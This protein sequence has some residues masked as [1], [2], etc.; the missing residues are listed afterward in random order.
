MCK[1]KLGLSDLIRV[2]EM[3]YGQKLHKL[4]TPGSWGRARL[5]VCGTAPCTTIPETGDHTKGF[6]LLVV[7]KMCAFI[8][9]LSHAGDRRREAPPESLKAHSK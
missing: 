5:E 3:A 2:K 7:R 4:S 8:K 1:E 6:S 9:I